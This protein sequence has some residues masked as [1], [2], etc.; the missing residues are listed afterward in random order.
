MPNELLTIFPSRLHF[1]CSECGGPIDVVGFPTREPDT[2]IVAPDD[3]RTFRGFCCPKDFPPLFSHAN[4]E[5]PL[6]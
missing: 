3:I 6:D 2:L 4:P 5:G 1:R